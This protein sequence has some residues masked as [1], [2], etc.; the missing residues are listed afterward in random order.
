V[1]EKNR[2]KCLIRHQRSKVEANSNFLHI[3]GN[4]TVG[5]E[6]FGKPLKKFKLP[7]LPANHILDQ[8]GFIF[9]NGA[10][11]TNP[12]RNRWRIGQ[13]KD[14]PLRSHF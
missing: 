8:F 1:S 5:D 14:L 13:W 11:Q 10:K 6:Q 12:S 3:S 7:S 2:P 4:E 9:L